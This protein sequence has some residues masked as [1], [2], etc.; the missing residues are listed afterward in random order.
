MDDALARLDDRSKP[1][2][3]ADHAAPALPAKAPRRK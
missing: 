2:E 1:R 3:P